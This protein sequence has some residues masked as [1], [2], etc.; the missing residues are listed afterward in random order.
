MNELW[1]ALAVNSP[2]RTL[3]VDDSVLMR[4]ALVNA[5]GPIPQCVVVGEG[6]N[7][8]EAVELA[9]SLCPDLVVMDIHMPGMGGL[10]ALPLL[11]GILPSAQVVLVTSVLEREVRQHALNLGAHACLEKGDELWHSLPDIVQRLCQ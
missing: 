7:G 8:H 10:E 5:L 9:R 1:V 6:A 3:V 2:L 11:K 4:K